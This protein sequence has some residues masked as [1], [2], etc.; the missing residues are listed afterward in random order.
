MAISFSCDCGQEFKVSDSHAGKR[1]KCQGC[2]NPVKIPDL[3]AKKSSSDSGAVAVGK[4]SRKKRAD[5]EEDPLVHSASEYDSA[6][7][8][9]IGNVPMGKLIEDEEGASV[10]KN[11]KKSKKSDGAKA[12]KPKKKK[13]KDEDAANPIVIAVFLLLG[14][15]SLSALGYFG[16]QKFGGAT[17]KTPLEK[18]FVVL[19]GPENV[20]SFEYPDDWKIEQSTGGTGGKPPVV[21]MN[22][23]GAIFRIK[24]SMGGSM[25]G[26]IAQAGGAGGIAVP[27][28]DDN[29]PVGGGA[30]LTPETAVHEFQQKF[31]KADYKEFEEEPMQKLK[32]PFGEGRLSVFTAKE[33]FLSP[34]IKGYRVT[35]SDNNWQYNLR[36]YV[37][38]GQWDK[39]QPTF[40]RMIDSISR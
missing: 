25:I 22:G 17:D 12:E 14:L 29:A 36:A 33:S 13:K 30:D 5:E 37:P 28:A 16:F 15:C 10:G 40:K 32:L 2:G 6:Y 7:E 35:F 24:G 21:L 31:F 20:F 11:G 23:D 34:K 19:K 26:S 38:E 27:G 8:F 18:K 39:F 4:S 3:K 9:D 1:I